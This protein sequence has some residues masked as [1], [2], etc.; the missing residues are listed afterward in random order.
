MER[1]VAASHDG[2]STGFD[3]IYDARLHTGATS[4]FIFAE[5]GYNPYRNTWLLPGDV[6]GDGKITIYDAIL[7]L[8][9]ISRQEVEK[10]LHNFDVT[11]DKKLDLGDVIYVLRKIAGL[12]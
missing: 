6:N 3:W 8:K 5:L 7:I 11:G 1:I 10:N 4:W 12:L 2:L 9:V